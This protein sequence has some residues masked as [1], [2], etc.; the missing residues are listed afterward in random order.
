MKLILY[1]QYINDIDTSNVVRRNT[2]ESKQF[3]SSC[4]IQKYCSE[5]T[6]NKEHKYEDKPNRPNSNNNIINPRHCSS[7]VFKEDGKIVYGKKLLFTPIQTKACQDLTMSNLYKE[8]MNNNFNQNYLT[9]ETDTE[10]L[11]PKHLTIPLLSIDTKDEIY[12]SDNQDSTISLC[13]LRTSYCYD[14]SCDD[15]KNTEISQDFQ[16]YKCRDHNSL[17]SSDSGLADITIPVTQHSPLPPTETFS[18]NSQKL[19][20]CSSLLHIN[21]CIFED[22]SLSLVKASVP[23]DKGVTFRS[24]LYAHWWLKK[25]LPG[26]SGSCDSGKI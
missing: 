13:D 6:H 2:N 24:E 3:L 17:R 18:N 5:G 14:N 15:E 16:Y 22:D 25:K 11:K 4:K 1:T 19:C 9:N 8:D 26:P 21:S 10:N 12:L 20:Q 23:L 7:M